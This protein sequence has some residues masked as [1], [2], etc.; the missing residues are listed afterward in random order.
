MSQNT[1]NSMT[2]ARQIDCSAVDLPWF[3][4]VNKAGKTVQ[5]SVASVQAAMSDFAA[6]ISAGQLTVDIGNAPGN[7]SWPLAYHT[8]L[9]IN[10][11]VTT[12][13]CTNVD[14]LLRFVAWALTNDECVLPLSFVWRVHWP[15]TP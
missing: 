10:Q 2:F 4:M 12:F 14:E 11:S 7:R 8:F 15:S 6:D 5:P 3:A 13:D 9:A 1:T